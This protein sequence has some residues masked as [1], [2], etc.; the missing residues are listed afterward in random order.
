MPPYDVAIVGGGII[1]LSVGWAITRRYPSAE[2]LVLEKEPRWAEHQTGHNSGEIHSG[3]YY[4]PGSLKAR[5][6]REGNQAMVKFCREYGIPHE[7]CGKLIVATDEE[8]LPLLE[9]LYARARLNGIEATRIGPN[10]IREIEPHCTGR[11]G[12]RVPSTAIVSYRHVAETFA[13]LIQKGNG[14]LQ[15][16]SEVQQITV[17]PSGLQ[18]ESH[19]NSYQARFLVNCAGLHSDRIAQLTGLQPG[20]RIIPIRGEYYRLRAEK[21]YLV[22]GLIYP[23]PNPRYPFLG[24]HFNRL[25]N[26]EVRVGPSAV[27]AFKREGYRKTEVNLQDSME[28]VASRAFWIFAGHNWREGGKEMLRALSKTL[29]LRRLQK[30][31]PD[32]CPQ[33]LEAAPAGVRAQALMDDGRLMD[34]FLIRQ[35][36]SSIHICNSP[37][38]AATASIPIGNAVVDLLPDG[39][40]R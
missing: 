15:L 10:E 7:V 40:L 25:M 1:G 37:S 16:N 17:L 18:I 24:A 8:E 30:L 12:L 5:F 36:P 22:K 31:I 34:D 38:P 32:I 2:I 14:R 9:E 39:L 23:V 29:F 3:I 19:S 35:G 27:V 4:E 21:R 26:G 33:D 20:M 13:E 11:A 28:L 6:C